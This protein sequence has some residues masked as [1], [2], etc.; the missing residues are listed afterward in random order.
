MH[1]KSCIKAVIGLGALALSTAFS[2]AQGSEFKQ[3]LIMKP[4][5][6]TYTGAADTIALEPNL[7]YDAVVENI[8]CGWWE[9]CSS[10]T[11]QAASSAIPTNL[12]L[13]RGQNYCRVYQAG[14][15]GIGYILQVKDQGAPDNEYQCLSEN[16]LKTYPFSSGSTNPANLGW[17]AKLEFVK[18]NERLQ[19]G[20]RSTPRLT[21]AVMT[22]TSSSSSATASIIIEPTTFDIRA[23]SCT[24]L[25]PQS[26]VDLGE[27]D[28][29][30]LPTEG[31]L[32]AA[33]SFQIG[34][35]CESGVELKMVMT[36]QSK[37]GNYSSTVSLTQDSSADGVGVQFSSYGQPVMLGPD[38]STPGTL[39]QRYITTFNK[40][41]T[42]MLPF[43]AR[44][45]RTGNIKPGS[46]N[47][48]ASITFSYQ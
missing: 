47:A 17:S 28:A 15:P 31:S 46:A 8:Y 10:G 35:K 36:D 30:D 27:I 26:Q 29:R 12:T 18:T 7:T 20:S 16:I 1:H 44:Y 25:T 3:N 11:V 45:V 39:N 41:E 21:A 2:N 33:V 5:N 13:R 22:G 14:I 43:E 24:V 40:A 6:I 19:P 9:T 38:S 4:Q 32:S 48:L 37:P 23:R 42:I 34:L